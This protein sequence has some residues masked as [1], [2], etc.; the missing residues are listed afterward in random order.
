MLLFE[1]FLLKYFTAVIFIKE[2]IKGTNLKTFL[3][4]ILS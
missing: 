2:Q 3:R 4:Y 1:D